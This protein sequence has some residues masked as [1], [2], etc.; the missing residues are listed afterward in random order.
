MNISEY[1][2]NLGPVRGSLLTIHHADWPAYPEGE[3]FTQALFQFT[4]FPPDTKFI[5][6]DDIDQA[7]LFIADVAC[8]HPSDPFDARNFHIA[9][10]HEDLAELQRRSF[11]KGIRPITEQQWKKKQWGE[12]R[13][14]IPQGAQLGF[15][16]TNGNFVPIQE[17]CFDGYED[18]EDWTPLVSAPEGRIHVTKSGRDFVNATLRSRS[19][20]INSTI[21]ERV[22]RLF[23]LQFF[24]TCI[25]EACV[26]LEHEIKAVIGSD[27]WGDR[28]TESFIQHLRSQKQ[29]LESGIRTFR[30]ELR[31]I[32]KLIRN[33]YMHNLSDADET[34]ALAILAR[35]SRVRSMF[36]K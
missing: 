30:Q 1:P 26:Q 21:S 13:S 33:D 12:F 25:R 18:E 28:L 27:A 19:L 29:F 35:I 4:A 34:S 9:A 5:V 15:K 3:D 11:I 2:G 6:V 32:F 31:S 36:T 24:D 8:G 14:A 10:W 7:L 23:E 17:P 16:D 20:D 22:H